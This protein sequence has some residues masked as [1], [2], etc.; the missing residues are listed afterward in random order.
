MVEVNIIGGGLAGCETAFYLAQRGIKVKLFEKKK[1]KKNEAQKS[2]LLAELVCSNSFRGNDISQGVGLLK[3]ELL[4]LGSLLMESA[5][6]NEVPAGGALAVDRIKFSQYITKTINEHPNI[7]VIDEEICEIDEN[8][9]TV[10][11]TG[12]LTEGLILNEIKRL[13]GDEF[14][15]FYDGSAPIVSTDSINM[16][17]V[18][19]ASRYDKGNPTDYLNA[20]MNEEEYTKFYK[21]LM[22]SE[23]N[24]PHLEGEKEKYFDGCMPIE[25]M[26]RRGEKTLLFGP[27]KPVGLSRN[28]ERHHG[29]VQLRAENESKTM[30]NLVGFQTGLIFSAQKELIH[31]IPGLEGTEILR[32]G[33]VHR[34]TFINS[35]K[36]L[37]I[38]GNLREFE[39]VFIA[40]QLSGVEGYVESAA[41]GLVCGMHIGQIINGKGNLNI[42]EEMMLGALMKYISTDIGNRKL[43][44]MNAN[45]G[46]LPPL[47]EK[48]KDKK[49]KKQKLGERSLSFLKEFKRVLED[50]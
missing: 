21:K 31:L 41:S 2:E 13:I 24:I 29:V 46:L 36:V 18:F 27:L 42:P 43:E 44:P 9:L 15:Y 19:Y 32:Y 37:T 12:P 4:E 35:P 3:K 40:G 39:N 49:L 28:G 7:E 11:A 20:P 45:F 10:L 14:C 48:I 47:D 5:L 33:V 16:D 23:K 38:K 1:I 17:K 50:G 6:K 34:N 8:K 26:A 22:N 25:E 30:Y